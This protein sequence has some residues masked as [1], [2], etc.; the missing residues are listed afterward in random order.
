[1]YT[2]FKSTNKIEQIFYRRINTILAVIYHKNCSK[3]ILCL[4]MS[5][6]LL[7]HE[8][9]IWLNS[10]GLSIEF[11]INRATII[12]YELDFEL[13]NLINDRSVQQFFTIQVAEWKF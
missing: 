10:I 4:C 13:L 1:M 6:I 8:L 2:L 11:I 3:N 5:A 7:L 9:C 12:R